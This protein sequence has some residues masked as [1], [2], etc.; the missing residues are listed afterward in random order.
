MNDN[1]GIGQRESLIKAFYRDRR[2]DDGLRRDGKQW[3]IFGL[4]GECNIS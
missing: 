1:S 4:R 3:N 2:V